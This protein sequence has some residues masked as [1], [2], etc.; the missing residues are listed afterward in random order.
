MKNFLILILMG[1][2]P[3]LAVG[4]ETFVQLVTKDST[5][6]FQRLEIRA[7][8]TLTDTLVVE[9]F[10]EKWLTRAELKAYQEG[11]LIP[12]LVER[13][14]ELNRLRR[15]VKNELDL[16]VGFYDALNGEGAWL[17]RQKALTLAGLAGQWSLIDRNGTTNRDDV[18][19]TGT[20]LRKNA[21]K[22]GTVTVLDDLTFTLSG[23]FNFDLTFSQLGNGTWR[24]VRGAR[25]FTLKR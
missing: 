20:E 13:Q 6:R 5:Y 19:V 21:N 12:A 25:T 10:P 1:L 18:T 11:Q 16:Q 17:A 7:I 2:L 24:A 14:T 22:F 9:R 23:Y 3:W 15:I 4:Q 8:E